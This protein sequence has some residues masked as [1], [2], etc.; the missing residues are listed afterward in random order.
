M[1]QDT[2]LD[3]YF[4]INLQFPDAAKIALENGLSLTALNTKPSKVSV[5]KG[6]MVFNDGDSYLPL[7]HPK[8]LL[9][10]ILSDAKDSLSSFD[11]FR[12]SD[13]GVCTPNEY[14]YFEREKRKEFE[15]LSF[16][17]Q[18][19]SLAA[20]Q[21]IVTAPRD[22]ESYDVPK[23]KRR[24]LT[25]LLFKGWVFA[26][27]SANVM[28]LGAEA[29]GMDTDELL[30]EAQKGALEP[31]PGTQIKVTKMIS[32]WD[33]MSTWTGNKKGRVETHKLSS[34]GTVQI[35]EI[36]KNN[37]SFSSRVPGWYVSGQTALKYSLRTHKSF[38]TR[39]AVIAYIESAM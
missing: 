24:T 15:Q 14:F 3:S 26:T 36:D 25:G 35:Y 8:V 4:H 21:E 2:R 20:Y 27:V 34:G 9:E 32:Q 37:G 11:T 38:S 17:R 23:P 30:N 22:Y 28:L 19:D 29:V 13:C 10:F 33:K 1:N 6:E 18:K 16:S 7:D 31:K 12:I 5:A 39:D